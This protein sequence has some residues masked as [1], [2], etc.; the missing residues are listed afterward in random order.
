MYEE[1]DIYLLQLESARL[2]LSCCI[3]VNTLPSLV[4]FRGWR[5]EKKSVIPDSYVRYRCHYLHISQQICVLK[6]T[7]VL[8]I[9]FIYSP[10]VAIYLGYEI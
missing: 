5:E 4:M 8:E 9:C 7:K 2:T 3:H 1:N 10:F 6:R